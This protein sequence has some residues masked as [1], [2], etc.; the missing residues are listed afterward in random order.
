MSDIKC[1]F[2]VLGI[3]A[4]PTSDDGGSPTVDTVQVF[5]RLI[6]QVDATL[7]TS[8]DRLAL[9][10][11]LGRSMGE[12]GAEN[13]PPPSTQSSAAVLRRSSSNNSPTA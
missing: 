3:T 5:R 1:I 12:T 11:L 4:V 10:D 6:G 8:E 2:R 13:P 9:I 7:L